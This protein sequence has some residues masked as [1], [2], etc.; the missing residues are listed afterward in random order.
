M[1][2]IV[3]GMVLSKLRAFDSGFLIFS[4]YA[5][6]SIRLG[7]L[8][9]IPTLH[10]FTHD[11]IGVGEDGPTHQPVEQLMSLRDIPHMVVIR[12]ADA[13]EVAE[14]WRV[15]LQEKKSPITLALTRQ[16][17]PTLDRTKYAPAAGLQ[18]GAYI[19]SDAGGQPDIIL[20]GT[21]SELQWC[22]EAGEKLKAEGVKVRL[23][24]MPSWEL[25]ERQPREY[26][27]LVLPPSVRKRLSV[28]AGVTLGWQ[29]YVGLDG[30]SI[31]QDRFGES[32]PVKDLMNHF[33]FTAEN[34]YK[35]AK[36]LLVE[37]PKAATSPV[38]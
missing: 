4:D 1:T 11:S 9:E 16:S 19:L 26:R 15:F 25:F 8:M 32:A 5:R 22:V 3:N 24:S 29:K 31:G 38:H 21:G 20:I 27:E 37:Q 13:N 23:I 2:A 30:A 17:V 10:V 36:M 12:P 35:T 6:G 7:C 34:V 28:E 18:H 14:A 33:G